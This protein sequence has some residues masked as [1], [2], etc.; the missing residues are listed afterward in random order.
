MYQKQTEPHFSLVETGNPPLKKIG[1]LIPEFPGQ[2]HNF[3]W[4]EIE[5]LR[6]L[7]SCVTLF[8]TRRPPTKIQS[9]TW[10]EAAMKETTYLHPPPVASILGAV[11]DLAISPARLLRCAKVFFDSFPVLEKRESSLRLLMLMLIGIALGRTCKRLE[12]NHIHV[13]SCA[14]AANV[15][16][17]AHA[18][19]GIEYSMTLHNPLAIWG[20]NQSNKWNA[21]KF[22]IVITDWIL[23]DALQKLGSSM[24]SKIVTAPMGVKVEAFRRQLPYS[25]REEGPLRV[26]SCARLNPAKGFEVLLESV[27]R[28]QR[29][30]RNVTLTIA[31]E[32][33]LGGTGYRRVIE[34]A[35]SDRKIGDR[36]F[37]L[38]AVSEDRVRAELEAAH[39]FV[40]A[41]YEEPLGVAIMEAMAMEVPVIATNAGGVP[42]IISDGVDGILVQPSD[43]LGLSDAISRI[44]DSPGLAVA[45]SAQGRARI[46]QAFHHRLSAKAI[47][48]NV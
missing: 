38:G 18:S 24:P 20:G 5:A 27:E 25:P 40:L 36:V 26:F 10:G 41:S 11:R 42:S 46:E 32:D 31:G 16:L 15:A 4:R 14:D 33:D 21:A 8:S 13:H 45:L 30:G 37:L 48:D 23:K 29:S 47:F 44:G 43:A 2:T 19:F 3:F 17:F 1:V 12:L 6:E 22:G 9:T 34:K 7:G 28:L 39:M 35:I